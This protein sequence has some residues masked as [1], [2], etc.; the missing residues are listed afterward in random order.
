MPR[1][2]GWAVYL[3][4]MKAGQ[5]AVRAICTQAEWEAMDRDRP[6]HFTLIQGHLTNEG[7][8]ERLARGRS[9]ETPP[10]GAKGR[11]VAEATDDRTVTR[12]ATP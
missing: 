11:V 3:M 2:E 8:A 6:G 12:A 10:R 5:D 9:G 7:Q 4:P 1:A